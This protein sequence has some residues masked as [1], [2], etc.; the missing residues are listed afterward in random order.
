MLCRK[1]VSIFAEISFVA[2]SVSYEQPYVVLWIS[3]S[4][5]LSNHLWDNSHVLALLSTTWSVQYNPD[6]H[7]LWIFL[8]TETG[9]F[10][11]IF[12]WWVSVC[13]IYMACM[14]SLEVDVVSCQFIFALINSFVGLQAYLVFN[15]KKCLIVVT[16]RII[17]MASKRSLSGTI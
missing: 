2:K 1:S 13:I 7:A 5:G 11:P 8:F 6:L 14:L 17:W 10:K 3:N 9:R 4:S 16:N 15:R 12:A